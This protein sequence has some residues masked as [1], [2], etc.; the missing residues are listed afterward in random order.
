MKR[1]WLVDEQKSMVTSEPRT[2]DF[3]K[4]KKNWGLAAAP[5]AENGTIRRRSCDLQ[6]LANRRHLWCTVFGAMSGHG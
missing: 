1:Y 5:T 2:L 3:V 4:L 6:W